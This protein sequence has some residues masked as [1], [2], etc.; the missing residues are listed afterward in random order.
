V[1]AQTRNNKPLTE[2]EEYLTE[3]LMD[4][5][6]NFRQKSYLFG[7]FKTYKWIGE[8]PRTSVRMLLWNFDSA[9]GTQY[10]KQ[11]FGDGPIPDFIMRNSCLRDRL[12]LVIVRNIEM[13]ARDL[14]ELDLAFKIEEKFGF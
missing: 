13:N 4:Y 14:D 2:K 6:K 10:L 12:C 3:I 1:K 8:Q 7:R 11:I 9:N 5:L